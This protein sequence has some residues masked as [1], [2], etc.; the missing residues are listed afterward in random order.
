MR[1]TFLLFL[2]PAVLQPVLGF[3]ALPLTTL[4]LTPEDYAVQALVGAVTGVLAMIAVLGAPIVIAQYFQTADE[5]DRSKIVTTLFSTSFI[6]S[7]ILALGLLGFW[8]NW[9]GD[10]AATRDVPSLAIWLSVPAMIATVPWVLASEVLQITGRAG[11]YALVVIG[12]SV[13]GVSALLIA[14]FGFNMDVISLFIGNLAGGVVASAGA[15]YV[16]WPYLGLR[17]SPKIARSIFASGGWLVAANFSDAVTILIERSTISAHTGMRALGLYAHSQQYM[18][19][20]NGAV[21]AAM[22]TVWPV[23]LTEARRPNDPFEATRDVW[24]VVHLAFLAAGVLFATFGADLIGLITNQRFNSAAPFA[25]IWMGLQLVRL[26][27]RPQ[28]GVVFANGAARSIGGWRVLG[29]LLAVALLLALIPVI[30]VWGAVIALF[31]QAL[32]VRI[33]F[34]VGARAFRASSW[35]DGWAAAGLIVILAVVFAMEYW[36]PD[37]AVRAA[38]LV[39]TML[40]LTPPALQPLRR[41]KAL[42][43]S[44]TTQS[45]A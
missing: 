39:T 41:A 14:L 1:R 34:S 9:G 27:G 2:A 23:T 12:Q 21:K 4:I 24:T 6:A 5:A 19:M 7:L 13:T 17:F 43:S 16:L 22:R 30:G 25:A 31:V 11:V 36:Q 26:S 20:T 45:E 3:L 33:G 15:L 8:A 40:A 44:S 38:V 37:K 28:Q 10:L 35:Q 32:V 18:I 29:N 42:L